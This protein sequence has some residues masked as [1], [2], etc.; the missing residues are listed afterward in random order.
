M[1]IDAHQHFWNFERVP[2]QW[3]TSNEAV[4]FRNIEPDELEEILQKSIIDKTIIVQAFDSYQDTDY[5][6]EIA[7]QRDWV[8]GVIG[9]L[10]LKKEENLL[11]GINKYTKNPYFKGTRHLIHNEED[12]NWIIQDDVIKGLRILADYHIPFDFVAVLPEHLKHVQYVSEKVPNL[13]IVIDHLGKPPIAS[14]DADEWKN[15]IKIASLNPNVYA[16]I[17][18]LNTAA[19]ADWSYQ[20]FEPYI[21]F[22]IE[23]FGHKRLMYGSDWPVANLAGDYESVLNAVEACL[24]KYSEEVQN[25]IF[26]KTAM[27]FYR[28]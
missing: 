15:L 5:M 2:Y 18:G 13:R 28:L 23:T 25:Y 6:L 9:W 26:G 16:K 27:E 12:I 19:K 17:S 4:I 20:D 7:E 10:P 21:D 3:P 24:K 14:G 8:I 22:A 1:K 11:A